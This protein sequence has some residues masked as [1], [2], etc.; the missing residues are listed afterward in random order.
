MEDSRRT[1]TRPALIA[2]AIGGSLLVQPRAQAEVRLFEDTPSVE[3][4]RAVLIPESHAS[5]SRRI[6]FPRHDAL[7]AAKPIQPAAAP[8]AMSPT[9]SQPSTTP[10]SN[11]PAPADPPLPASSP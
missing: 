6:E 5:A 1:T 8:G 4:L 3:Q 2:L 10:P 7:D 11:A 9:Q